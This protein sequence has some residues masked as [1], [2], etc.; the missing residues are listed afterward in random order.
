[1]THEGNHS[2]RPSST[3]SSTSTASSV[4]D[5]HPLLY[6]NP[7]DHRGFDS[8]SIMG[9][10]RPAR[11]A[12]STVVRRDKANAVNSSHAGDEQQHQKAAMTNPVGA[13]VMLVIVVLTWVAEAEVSQQV[14]AH[15]WDHPYFFGW[16]NRTG[17]MLMGPI[18]FAAQRR[19]RF[20]PHEKHLFKVGGWLAFLYVVVGY[21][22]YLS[23]SRTSV[24]LNTVIYNSNCVF[25]FIL[26]AAVLGE[27]VTPL[28]VI[29]MFLSISGLVLVTVVG[30]KSKMKGVRQTLLGYILVIISTFG[31]AAFEVLFKY[32]SSKGPGTPEVQYR[33]E[34]LANDDDDDDYNDDA[35]NDVVDVEA[36]GEFTAVY[37]S[38]KGDNVRALRDMPRSGGS[39]A[40]PDGDCVITAEGIVIRHVR[41]KQVW[42]AMFVL[43]TMG[44]WNA[45]VWWFP[46]PLLAALGM[47]DMELPSEHTGH[48]VFLAVVLD[49]VLNGCLLIGI[50]W[51][52]PLFMAIGTLLTIPTSALSDKI[53]HSYTLSFGAIV[54]ILLIVSGF[55]GFT[56]EQHR[57][58]GHGHGAPS[59]STAKKRSVH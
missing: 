26:S 33:H 53:M 37:G 42:D 20:T 34:Q 36:Q 23:L 46:I 17:Y 38:T 4:D 11:S 58:G 27:K 18:W 25:V 50:A 35:N 51:S 57:E 19:W 13:A 32:G 59:S 31:Y 55:A 54:G 8:P 43:T 28:K 2:S 3:S 15:S 44:F 10:V 30:H 16:F 39:H 7:N 5:S 12:P 40:H 14:Q 47:E 21:T 6:D 52:S 1:M 29:S 48:Y 9:S 24:S 41:Y 45:F 56:Y 22:W 49:A